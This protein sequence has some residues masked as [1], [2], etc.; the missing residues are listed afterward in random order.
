MYYH[1]PLFEDRLDA[2]YR[3]AKRLQHYRSRGAIVLAVPRGGVPIG[4]ALAQELDAELDVIV[5]RKIPIPD[6]PEAGFGAVTADGTIVLNEAL[7]CQLG[8]TNREIQLL[9]DEVRAEIVRRE[10]VYRAGRKPLEL[11]GRTAII[12]D[13]G[14]ASGYTMIAA[15]ESV[16]KHEPR[17]IVVAVPVS[18]SDA[19]ERVK[20]LVDEFVALVV[21]R[22]WAFAVASFYR[23]WY[24]LTD[25]E[26]IDYLERALRKSWSKS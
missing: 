8:L 11:K 1:R 23:N 13:D 10:R 19:A 26:V 15:I 18:S 25:Q 16:R 24:D 22:A 12:T 4:F 20:P 14:L 6:N 17:T 5:P 7:V 3:L 21:S 2:G 9:A